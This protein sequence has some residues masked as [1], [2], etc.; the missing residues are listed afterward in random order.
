MIDSSVPPVVVAGERRYP[1]LVFAATKQVVG[2]GMRR[3]DVEQAPVGQ[4]SCR[5]VLRAVDTVSWSF[6]VRVE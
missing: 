2:T 4:S 1:R 6:R 5:L 3:H